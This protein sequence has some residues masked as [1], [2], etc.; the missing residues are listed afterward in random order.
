[1][2]N[3]LDSGKGCVCGHGLFFFV[4]DNPIDCYGMIHIP[5]RRNE[6]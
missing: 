4:R 3:Q 1:M 5:E 6:E 2:T